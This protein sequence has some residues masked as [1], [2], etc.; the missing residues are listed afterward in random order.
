MFRTSN[1]SSSGGV[2]HKQLT[3]FDHAEIIL[4]LYEWSGYRLS[5]YNVITNIKFLDRDVGGL[6]C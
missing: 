2:L 5:S 4:Q 6:K 3:A 1:C